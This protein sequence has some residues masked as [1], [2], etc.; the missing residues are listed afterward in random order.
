MGWTRF[1]RRSEWDDERAREL[2]AHLAIE[3]DENI[4]RGMD[5]REARNAARRKL[6]NVTRVREEIY[7]MNTIGWLDA[8]LRDLKYG[9]RLLRLNP[10]F[11]L[12]AILSL[13]L[14]IGANTAIFQLLDAVRLRTLPV[15]RPQDLAEIRIA[16]AKSGR[17]GR[18]LGR[19]PMLTHPLFEQIR[20][21][22]QAFSGLAAWGTAVFNLTA[23]GEARYAQGLW[24]N[25]DFFSTLGV[26][27][28]AGRLITPADDVRGCGSPGVVVGYGFWQREL[29]G[30]VRAVGRPLR[31]EGREFE[32]LGVAAPQ[33]FGVEVGRAFDVALPLC[34]EPLTRALSGLDKPDFWFLAV[35]GRLKPG[36]T[37]ERATAHLA[38]MSRDIFRITL[39]PKY[40]PQDATSYVAFTLGA[41]PAGTGVSTL[42]RDYETPLWLLLATT[43]LVLAI[44]CANLAN[45]MLA[46]ATAREREIAVRLAI[47]AS[48]GR[49]VSQLL[50]ESLLLSTLGAAGGFVIAKWL[51]AFL[52]AFL[53]TDANRIFVDLAADWRVFAFTGALA[54]ATCLVFGLTPA[55]R[56]TAAEP[57]AAMKAGSRGATDTRERFGLRRTLVVV[58]VA[59]S[60]VLLVGALLFVR[61]LRNLIVLDAGFRQDGVLIVNIDVRSTSIPEAGRRAAFDEIAARLG[62]LPGVDSIAE[63]A[64]VP[65]SGSV[66]NNT[67]VVRGQARKENVNFNQVGRGYFNAMATPIVAGRD[68]EARDTPASRRVAI[69]TE[70]FA[71][72]FFDG[73]NPVGATFQIE[74]GVG[75]ERP[76]YEIVG[77]VKDAKYTSLREEFMPIIFLASAQEAM[78]DPDV[79]FVVRSNAPILALTRG[80]ANAVAQVNP[81]AILE[82][83]SMNALV[84][85]SLLRERLMA[86]LSGFFGLLAALLATIGLYGV[87]SYMVERRRNEIG[88]RIALGADRGAVVSMVMR[89]AA[90]LLVAGIVV[91]GVA[92]IAAARWASTLLFGLRP[93]DPATFATA[94]VSLAA[95]AALASFVPAWRAAHLEPTV[96]LRQE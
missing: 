18:F 16:D 94:A 64:I 6:G 67:I 33:F 83:Q 42:R 43:G 53:T 44:A 61:S 31:I 95:V 27:P 24:V 7:R 51:S 32:V 13:A 78:P 15:D 17:T 11:A 79:R 26:R 74:E 63:V 68:F 21:R 28:L 9:A 57:V 86:T 4:A 35:F 73:G 88:I 77:L 75:V 65:V 40:R 84:R 50:A 82:F 46:R 52:I 14:G 90:T 8:F 76:V 41:F 45:L 81:R 96:A 29:G 1:L 54:V 91:G 36:W 20:D 85:E 62:G 87:M 70:R 30:D 71:R 12:V 23:G 93:G 69:V 55:I 5:P 22:Q 49:V 58:Q 25:G 38:S 2:E 47:G 37:I 72:T 60:L 92:A 59:L 34:A 3:T 48:R 56:A 10:G 89:E 66:W 80:I 19:R 39:P